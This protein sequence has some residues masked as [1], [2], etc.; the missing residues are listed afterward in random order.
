MSRKGLFCFLFM[1]LMLLSG[2][3]RQADTYKQ[4]VKGNLDVIYHNEYK[5]Y[6]TTMKASQEDAQAVHEQS[7][8]NYSKSFQEH[9][10]LD[11]T[12]EEDRQRLE[13]IVAAVCDKANYNVDTAKREKG[14]YYVTVHVFPMDY[15]VKATEACK[16]LMEDMKT[17]YSGRD[18]IDQDRYREEY[19]SR[20][21]DIMEELVDNI[22]YQETEEVINLKICFNKESYYIE[23]EDFLE[24]TDYIFQ[25]PQ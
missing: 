3:G 1:A 20:A 10:S 13:T 2:C 18:S 4:Y 6:I 24:V 23:D 9:L 17:E 25:I 5:G 16:N 12:K 21:L 14:E 11:I 8:K 22:Q 19:T 7:I 15:Q